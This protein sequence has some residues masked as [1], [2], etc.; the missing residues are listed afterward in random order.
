MNGFFA[1]INK[2]KNNRKTHIKWKR[3]FDFEPPFINKKNTSEN[4]HIEQNTSLKFKNDKLWIDTDDFL[5]V[6]EGI[7]HNL[8]DLCKQ[9]N[10]KD[11][12]ELICKYY[13]ENNPTFFNQFEGNFS[14]IFHD[15]RYNS[16]VAFNNKTGMKKVFYYQ[17]ADYLIYSSDLKLICQWLNDS[18]ITYSLNVESAYLLLTSGF[19]H[20]DMTLINEVNQL[21]AGEYCVYNDDKLTINSYFNLKNILVTN[22]T[23]QTIIET[24]DSLFKNAIR[25]E[26]D[27]DNEYNYKHLTTLSG[28]LDSRMTA[29]MAHKMGYEQQVFLNFSEKGYADEIIANEIAKSYQLELLQFELNAQSLVNIDQVVSVNN[30]LTVYTA[31]SHVFSIL[32]KIKTTSF[33]LIHT[34]MIGDAVMGSFVSGTQDTKPKISDGLYSKSLLKKTESILQKTISNYPTEELYKFYNRAFMGANNGCQYLD[35]I[36]ETSSPFLNSSFLSYAYSIPRK[37]KYKE[38]IYI[39]WIKTLHPDIASFTWEGIGGKPTNNEYLRQFYR[40]KR[41]IIKRLPIK[42]MWKNTMSPEQIWYDQHADVRL[43][44]DKYFDENIHFLDSFSELR[45]DVLELFKT[46][47]ITEKTQA[48]TL[49]SACKLHFG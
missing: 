14:G 8:I 40:Y 26:F 3:P 30:G 29:L 48:I 24:L 5:C 42:T 44:L 2:R 37:Y 33:G 15:K 28:G 19:M 17:D 32:D 6:S 34:G 9:N 27:K 49:L 46:G 43:T 7:I 20:E 1:L 18:N 23:K 25:L 47:N 12:T 35:L 16:W 45:A 38:N 10:C 11:S 41:A 39:D 21:R 4:Y 36:G 13:K 22:D 31:C